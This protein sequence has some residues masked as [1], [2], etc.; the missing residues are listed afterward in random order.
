LQDLAL[1]P[2]AF[3]AGVLRARADAA[4]LHHP[5]FV[6][7]DEDEVGAGARRQRSAGQAE[8]FCGRARQR[9]DQPQQRHIA[10]VM[11]PERCPEQRFQPDRAGRC[12]GKRQALGV[13]ILRIM[14]GHDD[15]DGAVLERLDHRQPVVLGAQRRRQPEEGAVFPDIIVVERQI[16]DRHA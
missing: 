11:Q 1:Q 9:F 2:R 15:V 4:L 3:E 10:I 6:E 5:G 8:Q 16:V 14:R 7:I 13:D 12:I